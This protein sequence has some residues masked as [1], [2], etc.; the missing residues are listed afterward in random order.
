[1]DDDYISHD[2]TLEDD[3]RKMQRERIVGSIHEFR[4]YNLSSR[5]GKSTLYNGVGYLI[6]I[7]LNKVLASWLVKKGELAG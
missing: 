3:Y 7:K 4:I 1:M 6:H 2:E 5:H